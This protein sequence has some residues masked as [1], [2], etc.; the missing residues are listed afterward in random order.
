MGSRPG[1]YDPHTRRKHY[2]LSIHTERYPRF[3]TLALPQT[4]VPAL[5]DR[6]P[7]TNAADQERLLERTAQN[8]AHRDSSYNVLHTS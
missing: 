2:T 8:K 6:K 7:P 1:S 3:R 4:H 5:A